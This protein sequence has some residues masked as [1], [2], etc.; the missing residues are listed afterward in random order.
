[1]SG[2][3]LPENLQDR[4]M[5][6]FID[7]NIADGSTC[8]LEDGGYV[9]GDGCAATS[10][11]RVCR[12]EP[13]LPASGSYPQA[14]FMAGTASTG[15]GITGE[16]HW[17]VT[18]AGYVLCTLR[19]WVNFPRSWAID[20]GKWIPLDNDCGAEFDITDGYQQWF[21]LKEL[22]A[23]CK[24][25]PYTFESTNHMCITVNLQPGGKCSASSTA[26]SPTALAPA[27]TTVPFFQYEEALNDESLF[28]CGDPAKAFNFHPFV[29]SQSSVPEAVSS[30]FT[31][32]VGRGAAASFSGFEGN[33]KDLIF[34]IPGNFIDLFFLSFVHAV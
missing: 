16:I 11:E 4:D 21:T 20:Y 6:V 32:Y 24:N 33:Q 9:K 23:S 19:W 10:G 29:V 30:R 3:V 2:N 13:T 17:D 15:T 25:H 8:A 22:S 18:Q 12:V 34:D 31:S 1:V 26:A 14:V 5:R 28:T 7:V 27:A